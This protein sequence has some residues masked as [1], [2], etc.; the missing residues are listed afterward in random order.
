MSR[1]LIL[2]T[3]ALTAAAC[4]AAP[5]PKP[6][7]GGPPPEYETPRAFN[8]DSPQNSPGKPAPPGVNL[9]A[10]PAPG[11]PPGPPAPSTP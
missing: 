5:V 9:P 11:P 3:V 2:A 7:P 1:F 8:L 4:S 6:L 10:T